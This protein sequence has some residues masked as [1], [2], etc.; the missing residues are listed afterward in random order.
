[1]TV[2][3]A[4]PDRQTVAALTRA[5][6]EPS[7]ITGCLERVSMWY[8]GARVVDAQCVA[9]PFGPRGQAYSVC[10]ELQ[11]PAPAD[12]ATLR[13]LARVLAEELKAAGFRIE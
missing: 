9:L 10:G 5:L 2:T 6:V 1:M 3:I 12:W 4:T 11:L 7:L 8:Q 13:Q